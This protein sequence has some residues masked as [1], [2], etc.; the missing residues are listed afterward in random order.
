[1][2]ATTKAVP[3]KAESQFRIPRDRNLEIFRKLGFIKGGK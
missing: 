2:Q 3:A 1:M